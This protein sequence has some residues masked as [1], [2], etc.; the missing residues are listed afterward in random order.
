M[1][2]HLGIPRVPPPGA[3]ERG[4]FAPHPDS[5]PARR[6][7]ALEMAVAAAGEKEGQAQELMKA[8]NIR[9]AIEKYSECLSDILQALDSCSAGHEGYRDLKDSKA[10]I[11]AN[12]AS[13]RSFLPYEYFIEAGKGGG[14]RPG[15]RDSR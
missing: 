1:T 9:Q 3:R 5:K 12:I 8:G 10:G 15:R 14:G 13:L 7:G 4:D 2:T 6:G 11:E